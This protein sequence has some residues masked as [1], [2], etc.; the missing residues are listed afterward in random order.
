MINEGHARGTD[1]MLEETNDQEC[2]DLKLEE[3]EGEEQLSQ[4]QA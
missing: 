2:G 4:N 3:L 1:I